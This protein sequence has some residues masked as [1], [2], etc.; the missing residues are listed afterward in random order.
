MK[1]FL[2]SSA[3][4]MCIVSVAAAWLGCQVATAQNVDYAYYNSCETAQYVD[5]SFTQKI[6]SNTYYYFTACRS[7]KTADAFNKHSLTTS[8]SADKAMDLPLFKRN[9]YMIKYP[10]FLKN[11][12]HIPHIHHCSIFIHQKVTAITLS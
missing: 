9:T 4:I 6:A 5:S 7:H 2:P 3:R 8:I 11:K 1:S 10:V 12:A